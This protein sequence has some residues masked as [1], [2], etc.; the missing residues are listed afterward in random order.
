MYQVLSI[1]HLKEWAFR[2]SLVIPLG[3]I[4]GCIAENYS[5]KN[6]IIAHAA[7]NSVNILNSIIPGIYSLL[8]LISS[9]YLVFYL[10]RNKKKFIFDKTKYDNFFMKKALI[11]LPMI[12]FAFIWILCIISDLM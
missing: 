11:S 9:I 5:I 4:C 8:L 12:L 3:L 2:T 1:P 6:S 10:I 7:F